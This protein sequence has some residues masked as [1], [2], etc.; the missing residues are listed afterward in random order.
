M[1]PTSGKQA[2]DAA[3]FGLSKSQH[4]QACTESEHTPR[5]KRV[6]KAKAAVAAAPSDVS[7]QAV[8]SQAAQP[9]V[10]ADQVEMLQKQLK[11]LQEQMAG[12][13]QVPPKA[14]TPVAGA[15]EKPKAPP[16]KR[17]SVT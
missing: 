11:Q 3:A 13:G 5:R 14:G 16:R 15:A 12:Q 1:E 2:A 8:A 4:H 7:D 10:T 9:S 17:V 6:P